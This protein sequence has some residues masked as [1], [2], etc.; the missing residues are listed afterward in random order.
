MLESGRSRTF[1]D[2]DGQSDTRPSNAFIEPASII[3][4]LRR[5]AA[6]ALLVVA[7]FCAL[8]L[9]YVLTATPLY[10]ATSEILVDT[11]LAHAD[12]GEGGNRSLAELGMDAMS[13]DSQVAVLTSQRLAIAVMKRLH[14]EGA[15]EFATPTTLPGAMLTR[16]RDL[17][18]SLPTDLKDGIPADVLE[19][20]QKSVSV[21]RVQQTYVIKVSFTD[22]SARRAAS[23]ANAL[24][25]VYSDAEIK[26]R[27]RARQVSDRFLQAK[28]DD[29][30]AKIA[31]SNRALD[32]SRSTGDGSLDARRDLENLQAS[33]SALASQADSALQ[34]QVT[35]ITAVSVLAE[36]RAPMHRSQPN[37]LLVLLLS[38]IAG[39]ASVIGLTTLK[40][41]AD[42]SFR[43]PGQ[44]EAALRIKYLGMFP[45]SARPAP[46][47]TWLKL[48]GRMV[49]ASPSARA[50][51]DRW[52][53]T[54]ADATLRAMKIAA[55]MRTHNDDLAVIGI[56][57]AI[58]GEGR[59]GIA[60]AFADVIARC[61]QRSLLVDADL[62]WPSLSKTHAARAGAGL[63]EVSQKHS[64]LNACVVGRGNENADFLPAHKFDNASGSAVLNLKG[65]QSLLLQATPLY[66]YVVLDLP[67]LGTFAEAA[68]L[69]PAVGA[70]ILVVEWGVTA[71]STV[72]ATVGE[73]PLLAERT[74][75][76]VFSKVD[77]GAMRKRAW[78]TKDAVHLRHAGLGRLA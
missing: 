67:P 28:L 8:G 33:Y 51:R 4:S 52:S 72:E 49:G 44:V 47:A 38:A 18:G 46:L 25:A 34:H 69:A 5:N 55:E 3:L 22:R 59:S 16:L 54:H 40:E 45:K 23:I 13:I 41:L 60:T 9:G 56:V 6:P 21:T 30:R 35:P 12:D 17:F 65:L 43:L 73:T 31:A 19:G 48:A 15:E 77:V 53:T 20:F 74:A 39:C 63:V 37:T 2:G 32:R 26:S 62:R 70:F 76:F 71:R 10:T 24:V 29:V 75:G 66:D 68:A 36:A 27:M 64:V 57:S 78:G 50:S 11:R 61:G 58:S 7:C 14:L 42:K 1:F